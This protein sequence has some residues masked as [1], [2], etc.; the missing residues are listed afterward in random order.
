VQAGFLELRRW[1]WPL[2]N[3]I[4]VARKAEIELLIRFSARSDQ[5]RWQ[6]EKCATHNR[7]IAILKKVT[8]TLVPSIETDGEA[9]Q[10]PTHELFKGDAIGTQ[11]QMKVIGDQRPGEA[12]GASFFQQSRKPLNEIAPVSIGAK[13]LRRSIPRTM[14]CCSRPGIS[15]RAWRGMRRF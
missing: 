11:Q 5:C 1:R 4:P 10:Q 6:V 12:V 8:T 9:G 2:E 3:R 13:M 7:L 14:T 15:M